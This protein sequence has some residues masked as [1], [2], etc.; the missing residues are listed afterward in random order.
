M[1]QTKRNKRRKSSEEDS[2]KL[3]VDVVDQHQ[4]CGDFRLLFMDGFRC[5]WQFLVDF[6]LQ[7]VGVVGEL[8]NF[9][10]KL[11][12]DAFV[13]LESF[14]MFEIPYKTALFEINDKH[15]ATPHET[16]K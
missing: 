4:F 1:E 14:E 15:P 10:C 8:H 3:V 5:R 6:M 13:A 2:Q 16:K 7:V 12:D 11:Y 9:G